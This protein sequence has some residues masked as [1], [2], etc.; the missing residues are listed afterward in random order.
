[1]SQI[2]ILGCG[3]LGF[4]LALSL[5][6]KGFSIKGSTTS[7]E[8]KSTLKAAQIDPYLIHLTEEEVKGDFTS[9]TKGSKMLII[10]VPPGMRRD[11]SP[12]FSKKTAALIPLIER[13]GIEQLLFVS[14]TSVFSDFQGEVDEDSSP[15]PDTTSGIALLRSEQLLMENQSFK[16]TV[17]RF[18]GLFGP[19]RHPI[20]YLAG[21]EGLSGGNA[22]VNLIHLEDC[23]GLIEKVIQTNYWGKILHGVHPNHPKKSDYYTHQAIKKNLDMPRFQEEEN[24]K[25]KLILSKVASQELGYIFKKP[26]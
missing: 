18:A 8:K 25:Y 14:S 5:Q 7:E 11:S 26:L 9:F 12:D 24:S 16:T 1:M 15:M 23:I 4:P 19:D 3:W 13:A 17:I 6:R 21:R 2:S 10:N 22:P 20:Y